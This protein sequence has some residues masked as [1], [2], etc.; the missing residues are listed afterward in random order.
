VSSADFHA[1]LASP[2]LRSDDPSYRVLAAENE[3][4]RAELDAA[5]RKIVH[6]SVALENSRH[7]GAA[8]GIVMAATKLSED[9]AFTAL[10][11]ISQHSNR[12][13]REI[14]EDVILTGDIASL[15]S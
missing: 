9:A 2:P 12:K 10:V 7:I 1:R 4:L 8:V 14:A 11:S 13:V 6:L 3:Q 5:N 15:A